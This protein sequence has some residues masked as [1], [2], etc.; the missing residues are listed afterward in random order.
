[1][2]RLLVARLWQ[3]LIVVFLATTISFFLIRA[4]P[5]D[6]FSFAGP[7]VTPARQAELRREAGFD[8]PVLE[9]YV[10]YV[11]NVARGHFGWSYS[12][13]DLVANVLAD[14]VPRTLLLAGV[15]LALSLVVGVALG[16]KQA[17][18]AGGAFDRTTSTIFLWLY[19]LP[20]FWAALMIVLIFSYWLPWFP[21]GGIV[22]A[23]QHDYMSPGN[24]FLDRV[25]HLVLPVTSI[26]ILSAAGFSRFQRAALLEI[27]PAD[28]VRTARAKGV[29]DR[30]ILWRHGLR[31]A[32]GPMITMFGLSLPAIIGGVVFIEWIF[33][34]PGMGLLAAKSVASRD[35]YLVTAIV[36]VSAVI[37][38]IGNLL[39]DLLHAA[40]DPRIRE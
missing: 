40:V 39:A 31:N 21:T 36:I 12:K 10:R 34:W 9:Q 27:L 28:F 30:R 22:D 33:D 25:K 1:V 17:A 15:G 2:R 11:G 14:A 6:S 5:G 13:H 18:N 3:S 24:A 26:V 16:V 32:A 35:Y 38:V 19:S 23:L 7:G 29:S 4:A 37:V 20:D 8:R